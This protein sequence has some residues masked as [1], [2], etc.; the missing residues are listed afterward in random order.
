MMKKRKLHIQLKTNDNKKEK[1][2][3]ISNN[4]IKE[5][6]SPEI[7]QQTQVDLKTKQTDYIDVIN[8]LT[9][10]SVTIGIVTG[11]F[12][13]YTYLGNINYLSIFP[14][15][16]NNPSSLVASAVSLGII[17]L[18][19]TLPFATLYFISP[20]DKKTDKKG[21]KQLETIK[22]PISILNIINTSL[23]I[24]SII[25]IFYFIIEKIYDFFKFPLLYVLILISLI[26]FLLYINFSFAKLYKKNNKKITLSEPIFSSF[27]VL[28]TISAMP[29]QYSREKS[30]LYLLNTVRFIE[31]PA[32]SSWYLLH[33]NFQPNNGIRRGDL[34]KLKQNFK[35]SSLSEKEK[36]EKGITCSSIPEQRNNALYGYMAWNLGDTK[37]FCP[38]TA[39]NNKGK[40][41]AAKLAEECIVISGKSLQILNGNYIDI[42]P[43]ER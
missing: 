24:L 29:S 3:S 21:R 8:K 10:I 35:C 23:L 16:I 30:I 25:V 27:L 37:V 13:A 17:Y 1:I 36:V 32:N 42:T 33:N 18:L 20:F 15:T 41:E 12:L 9:G 40:E 7:K 5:P 2:H 34:L 6:T 14:D 28:M 39:E 22:D 43:K 11:G 31:T 38:P 19:F 4:R 26:I